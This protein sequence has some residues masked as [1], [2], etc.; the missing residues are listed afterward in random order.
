[1]QRTEGILDRLAIGARTIGGVDRHDIGTSSNAG[2]GV[3][4]R[5]R[6]VNA[7]VSILP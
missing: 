2:A 5:R 6:D 7:L 4:Q 1:M 3:T